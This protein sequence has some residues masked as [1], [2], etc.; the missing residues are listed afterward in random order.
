MYIRREPGLQ[1]DTWMCRF[2]DPSNGEMNAV[3]TAYTCVHICKRA[4]IRIYS[5]NIRVMISVDK[6]C[7]A[8]DP[9]HRDQT[10]ICGLVVHPSEK[11]PS[12]SC[13]CQVHRQGTP[14]ACHWGLATLCEVCEV[15]P[16][17]GPKRWTSDANPAPNFADCFWP[18]FQMISSIHRPRHLWAQQPQ[19]CV[20]R[21]C[22]LPPSWGIVKDSNNYSL[23]LNTVLV[24][25]WGVRLNS[26]LS[27]L[28]PTLTVL[29]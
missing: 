5:F 22:S 19:I 23:W 16:Q 21:Q 9:S 10:K 13:E 8:W 2:I 17:A 12:S 20:L 18:S 7:N 14:R 15:Q 27:P 26:T 3:T 25:I 24:W 4:R 6:F 28:S 11:S 1:I 29:S